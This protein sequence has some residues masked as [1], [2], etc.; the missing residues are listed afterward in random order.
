MRELKEL[1]LATMAEIDGGR[2]AIAFKQA[3]KRCAEDCDDRP[4]EKK[5]RT[6]TLTVAVEPRVDEDG[7]CEDCD[8]RVTIADNVPK[9]KSKPYNCSLRKGGHLMFHPDSL[10]DHEQETFNFDEDS[11][12]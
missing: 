6:I 11:K 1:T 7:L 9:R 5:A 2:L 8:V 3:L 10:D 12:A 4:G